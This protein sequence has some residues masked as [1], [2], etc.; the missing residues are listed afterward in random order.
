MR[1]ARLLVLPVLVLSV[2]RACGDAPANVLDESASRF[3]KSGDLRVHYKSVGEG[4]TAVVFIHGWCCDHSVWRLQAAGLNGKVRMLFVDL[5]G[6][7]QSD[8]PKIDYTMDVFARAT[9]AVL[10]D[11]GVEK[12]VLVGHSM[13]TPVVRQFYRLFPGKTKALVF[14]DGSLRLFRKDPAEIEKFL[15]QF[16]EQAFK[17]S[18]TKYMANAIRPDTPAAIR[19]HIDKLITSTSPQVGLSS[20]RGLFDEKIWKEDP[21]VFGSIVALSS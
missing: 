16:N 7:G 13:G 1:F 11:A 4:S 6:Y 20:F 2:N 10:Q 15:S 14:V 21:I 19:E 18:A 3:G 9:D 12:A 8:Q 17:E 5:P